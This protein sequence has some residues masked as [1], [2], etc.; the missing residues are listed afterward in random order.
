[1]DAVPF[2]HAQHPATGAD[3]QGQVFPGGNAAVAVI[4]EGLSR[5]KAA[6]GFLGKALDYAELRFA[7]PREPLGASIGGRYHC[8][9]LLGRSHL[10]PS[11]CKSSWPS[12][13]NTALSVGQCALRKN[14]H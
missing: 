12:A 7:Q 4:E 6:R 10:R 2:E 13:K 9:N 3:Q 1:M 14:Q 8:F 5:G 11:R